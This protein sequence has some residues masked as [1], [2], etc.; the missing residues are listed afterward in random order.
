[1][2]EKSAASRSAG[3]RSGLLDHHTRSVKSASVL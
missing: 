2:I 3:W 1:M